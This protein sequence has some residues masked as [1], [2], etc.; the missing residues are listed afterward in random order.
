MRAILAYSFFPD[1]NP[2]TVDQRLQTAKL[3]Q[4]GS[5]SSFA[6]I[7]AC[8]IA[9]D[10]VCMLAQLCGQ[11]FALRFVDIGNDCVCTGSNHHFHGGR[12]EA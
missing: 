1:G 8:D 10:V 6:V 11:C 2:C 12:T 4:C 9:L 5:D 3:L 7:F